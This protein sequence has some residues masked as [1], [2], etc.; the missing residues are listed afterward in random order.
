M[1]VMLGVLLGSVLGTR[2]LVRAKSRALRLIFAV[3]IVALGI[4]MI[5]NGF[6]GKL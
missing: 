4:E 2:V 3:V 5:Y 6:T 1:P